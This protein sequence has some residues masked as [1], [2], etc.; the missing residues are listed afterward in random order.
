MDAHFGE[1]LTIDGSGGDPRR[2][3]DRSI[4]L[5]FLAELPLALG[6]SILG[7]PELYR[8]TGNHAK[9]PGGWTGTTVINESHVSVHTFPARAFVSIDVYT[10]Q[11]G[12]DRSYIEAYATDAFA[13]AHLEVNFLIRGTCYPREDLHPGFATTAS[14]PSPPTPDCHA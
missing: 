2:L 3:D 7:G 4:V 8:A 9:D 10:C 11:N 14:T 13:L 1:H 12:L 6:M 5:R